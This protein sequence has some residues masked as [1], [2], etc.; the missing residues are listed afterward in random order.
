MYNIIYACNKKGIIKWDKLYKQWEQRSKPNSHLK[1]L[2]F[3]QKLSHSLHVTS[4]PQQF[5]YLN[6]L[7]CS[8]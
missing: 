7:Q 4:D 8:V 1:N 3:G 6:A 5:R 2:I